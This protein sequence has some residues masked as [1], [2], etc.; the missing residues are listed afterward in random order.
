MEN[1]NQIEQRPESP[2][3]K[4]HL[5][6]ILIILVALIFIGV[7]FLFNGFS[8][9]ST[10]KDPF[11]DL[12][13]TIYFSSS[14]ADDTG[15]DLYEFDISTGELKMVF[16]EFTD[17]RY[18]SV[19]SPTQ[20][21]MA[22]IASPLDRNSKFYF[23]FS[24][25]LQV[26]IRNK[27]GNIVKITTS[28][29]TAKQFPAWSPDGTLLAFMGLNPE[30]YL[31]DKNNFYVPSEWGIYVIDEKNIEKQVGVGMYP[32]WSPSG[33][34]VLALVN[35]G[36]ALYNIA[37]GT[38]GQVWEFPA[39]SPLHS[40]MKISL[41]NDYKRLIWTSPNAGELLMLNIVSWDPYEA[42]F[43]KISSYDIKGGEKRI[44]LWPIFSPDDQYIAGVEAD[45]NYVTGSEKFISPT[46]IRLVVY[47]IGD[48][49]NDPISR[50]E[51]TNLT[52]FNSELI[53][54]SDWTY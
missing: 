46:N 5:A 13:G 22:Y 16:D 54:L 41:S 53:L 30:R 1:N 23:P 9:K 2:K 39:S 40:V 26:F 21:R 43:E 45:W 24:E 10:E 29:T 18:T 38:G 17:V 15:S 7:F 6:L 50:R 28:T 37:D 34:K 42:L 11:A 47:A 12:K 4:T 44:L 52:N 33:E 49:L 35:N 14:L 3:N 32:Q 48:T 36:L 31:A 19:F 27:E 51:L 20:T 25:I 8:E